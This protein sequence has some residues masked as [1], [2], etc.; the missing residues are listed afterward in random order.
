MT[1]RSFSIDT[2]SLSTITPVLDNNFYA[3]EL[4]GASITGK[5]NKEFFTIRKEKVWDKNS[6]EMVETGD[7]EL[8]GMLMYSVSLTSKKAIKLLQQDEP[9]IF[10]GMIFFSFDKETYAMKDNVQ[11][12][13][14][15]TALDLKDTNF[16]ELVDFEFNDDIKVPE[17]LESV[18]D[19][20]TKLNALEYAKGLLTVICQTINNMPC[21]AKVIKQVQRGNPDVME[22]VLDMG[23]RSCPFCGILPYEDGCENDLEEE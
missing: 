15:L 12:G 6:K 3:G 9:R 23:S 2:T 16:D 14:L 21:K 5:E 8:N 10:G 18:P 7:Y 20:V 19:I 1:K 11:L 13:Q 4:V 22:N 17:E